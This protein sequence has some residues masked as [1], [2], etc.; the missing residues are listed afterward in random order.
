LPAALF[1]DPAHST[2]TQAGDEPSVCFDVNSLKMVEMSPEI[3]YRRTQEMPEADYCLL[4]KIDFIIIPFLQ[5]NRGLYA[6]IGYPKTSLK[7][8]THHLH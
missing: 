6:L 7:E 4:F 8:L 2:I 5:L 1:V 3:F